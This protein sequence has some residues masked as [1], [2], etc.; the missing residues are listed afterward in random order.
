MSLFTPYNV[1]QPQP[2]EQTAVGQQQ[3][4]QPTWDNKQTRD[5]IKKYNSSPEFFTEY[6][7]NNIRQHAAHHNVPFYEGEFDLVDALAQA[8]AGFFEGFTTLNLMEPADNEYEQIF[9]NLGHLAGFAPGI[10]ATPF[11]FGFKLTGSVGLSKLAKTA[12]ALNDKSVPMAGAKFLTTKAKEIAKPVF[13]I[14]STGHAGAAGD[15]MSFLT[16]NQARHIMEGAFHLGAASAISSWQGG[17]DEMMHSFIHG[18]QAGAVFRSIGNLALTGSETSNKVIRG[19]A[20]SLFMGLPATMRGATTPEQIYEYVMGAYFGKSERPWTEKG[21]RKMLGKMEELAKTNPEMRE[22]MLPELHPDFPEL[23]P[24]VQKLTKEYATNGIPGTDFKGYKTPEE[25][26]L[27]NALFGNEI[28][29]KNLEDI[30]AEVGGYEVEQVIGAAGEPVLRYK[31]GFL[32]RFISRMVSGGA[33][34]ADRAW[35]NAATKLGIPVFNFTFSRHLAQAMLN[36]GLPR[37]LNEAE[38]ERANTEVAKSSESL[39]RP[40]EK[41]SEYVYNLQR[42]NWHIVNAAE[43]VYAVGPILR[44]GALRMKAVDGGTGWGVDMAIR[45]KKDVYVFDNS[46]KKKHVGTTNKWYKYSRTLGRFEEIIEPPKPPKNWGGIGSREISKTGENAIE[47]FL[48]KHFKGVKIA[49]TEKEVEEIKSAKKKGETLIEETIENTKKRIKDVEETIELGEAELTDIAFGEQIAKV[50]EKSIERIKLET[51]ISDLYLELGQLEKELKIYTGTRDIS[52]VDIVDGKVV[53]AK[54]FVEVANTGDTSP[55]ITMSPTPTAVGFAKQHLS[56]M[57][58]THLTPTFRRSEIAGQLV[59]KMAELSDLSRVD[60]INR[61]DELVKWVEGYAKKNGTDIKLNTEAQGQLRQW[62]ARQIFD[63]QVEY[64]GIKDG[65]VRFLAKRGKDDTI[66]VPFTGAGVSKRNYEPLKLLQEVY[67]KAGGKSLR[68]LGIADHITI[69]NKD[70][71]YID[72]ELMRYQDKLE[73]EYRFKGK[74]VELARVLA[75]ADFN[76]LKANLYKKLNDKDY[77]TYGGRGDSDRMYFVKYHPGTND[78]LSGGLLKEVQRIGNMSNEANQ[79]L[80]RFQRAYKNKGGLDSKMLKIIHDKAYM[81]NIL[82]EMALNGFDVSTPQAIKKNAQNM[83]SKGKSSA[84]GSKTIVGIEPGARAVVY[85]EAQGLGINTLRKRNTDKHY[86]NPWS[87]SFFKGTKFNTKTIKEAVDNYTSWLEGTKFKDVEPARRKWILEQVKKGEL[88]DKRLLYFKGG[89]RSHADALKDFVIKNG[90][91]PKISPTEIIPDFISNSKAFNKRSQIWL[92]NGY[93]G[94]SQ[95]IQ[96]YRTEKGNKVK[97]TADGK[98]RYILAED[99]P[100]SIR[101]KM[102][103]DP[104]YSSDITRKSTELGEHIDG[105]IITENRTLRALNADAGMPEHHVQN[106]SFIV[107]PNAQYGA[108]LGKYMMHD[109]G[110]AMSKYMRDA[111]INFIIQ[112]SAAKQIGLRKMGAYKVTKTKGL[113]LLGSEIY[114]LDFSHIKYNY[115]VKTDA[116]MTKWTR[117]VK[118]MMGALLDNSKT[119]FK[120]ETIRDMLNTLMDN[121]F[122]G[123]AKANQEYTDYLKLNESSK[124]Q[125]INDVMK[126]IDNLGIEQMIEGIR[127][128]GNNLFAERLYEYMLSKNKEIL[129]ADYREGQITEAEYQNSMFEINAENVAYQKKLKA[130]KEWKKL[131]PDAA[132]NSVD[133]MLFDKDVRDYRMQVI[134][135][136]IVREATRPIMANS[137]IA[138]MRPYDKAMQMDLDNANPRLKELNNNDKI[139]FLDNGFKQMKIDTGIPGYGKKGI[140]TLGELWEGRKGTYKDVAPEIFETLALRVPMDSV[141]GAHGLTFR[142]FTGRE[143]YGTLLH[144]RTMR[145]LGGADLDGDEAHIYFGG[146]KKGFKKAWREGFEANKEEFYYTKNGKRYVGDNKMSEIPKELIKELELA[147]NI[148]T[149]QDLLTTTKEFK[150]AERNLLNSRGAMYSLHERNRISEA[151]SRGRAQMGASAVVPKQMMQQLHSM[152]GGGAGDIP[153]TS[154]KFT[155]SRR[156]KWNDVLKKYNFTE[157]EV[158]ITPR[159][160]DKWRKLAQEIGRAQVAFSSDPMDELGLKS[161]DFWFKT[162]HNAHFEVQIL[163]KQTKKKAKALTLKDLTAW[164]LKKGLYGTINNLNKAYW[165]KNY[166][167][168]RRWTMDEI[169]SMSEAVYDLPLNQRNS[170]LAKVG[171]LLNPLDW[172]DNAIGRMDATAVLDMYKRVNKDMASK[173]FR[174][175][176]DLLGRTSFSVPESKEMV[177]AIFTIDNSKTFTNNGKKIEVGF[178]LWNPKRRREIARDDAVYAEAVKGLTIPYK[179]LN[180]T[181]SGKKEDIIAARERVLAKIALRAEDYFLNDINDMATFKVI[182]DLARNMS[183]AELQIIPKLHK[184]AE[185]IKDKSYLMASQ[186]KNLHNVDWNTFT[187]EMQSE[188]RKWLKDNKLKHFIPEEWKT[189]KEKISST[190]DRAEIDVAIRKFRKDNKLSKK[191]AEMLDYLLLGT[192]KRGNLTKIRDLEN[193]LGADDPVMRDMISYMKSMAAGTAT[194]KLGWNSEALSTSKSMLNY[195]GAITQFFS[196][197]WKAPTTEQISRAQNAAE[198]IRETVK[199]ETKI[200]YFEESVVPETIE[201]TTGFEGLKE[202]VEIRNVSPELREP[203]TKLLS[204]IKGENNKFQNEFNQVVRSLLGKDINVLNYNDYN[205]LNRWFKDVKTGTIWQQIWGKDGPTDLAKR[206]YWLFPKTINR[207]LMKDDIRLM[208][209]NGL[210]LAQGG[211]ILTGKVMRPTQYVDMVQRWIARTMDGAS[212]TADAYVKLLKENLLFVNSVKEGEVLRQIAVREREFRGWD[213][214]KQLSVED[215][216]HKAEYRDR[217]NDI[218]KH[219]GDKLNQ[220]FNVQIDGKNR[221]M[222]GRQIVDRINKKYTEYFEEMYKFIRGEENWLEK[223]EMIKGYY[224]GD[225]KS[226]I[227]D[228]HRFSKF[229]LDSW[230][231]GENVTTKIG[232]DN[233]RVLA[234]SLMIDM[235]KGTPE[236][237]E[238]LKS[239]PIEPTNK[240]RGSFDYYFPHMHFNKKLAGEGMKRLMK[241]IYETPLS[242]FD[243]NPKKARAKRDKEVKKVIYK[244]HTLTG[245]WQFKE[246]ED[247]ANHDRIMNEIAESRAKKKEKVKWPVDLTKAGNMNSRISHIP[248]WSID[249]SAPEAYARAIVNTYYRQLAQILS[250]NIMQEMYGKMKPIWGE[251]QAIAWQKFMQLYVQDAIGNPTVIPESYVNDPTM[252]L[253]G[254]PYAW[255]ADSNVEKRINKAFDAFGLTKRDMPWL[256]KRTE[257]EEVQEIIEVP[258]P[259]ASPSTAILK[260]IKLLPYKTASDFQSARFANR[261]KLEQSGPKVISPHFYEGK[262]ILGE[263]QVSKNAKLLQDINAPI[264]NLKRIGTKESLKKAKQLQDTADSFS[265][266]QTI[267]KTIT[268]KVKKTIDPAA[269]LTGV[270][271]QQLRHWSNLEG[272]FEMAALLAHPKSAITNVFGGTIHTAQSAGWTN[273]RNARNIDWLR[274]NINSEWKSM[275]DVMQFVVESGV[276]PEY[277][278]YE[279]GLNKEIRQ[280]KNRAFIEDVA[281]KLAN[282]PEM[283]ETSLKEIAKQYGVKDKVVQFAAKFMTVPERM[284]RRDSFM[285]HYIQAWQRYGG[286]ITDPKH[287]F[288]IE[289]AKKGVQATQFLYSAPFRPA[290]AR[291]ALG[292]VMTRFQLWSWNAVRFRNDV[293]RQA[294]IYGLRPGSEEFERYVRT[295]QTDIFTF[296]LANMFAYSIFETALPAP[297]NW[298]QDTAD[299]VFGNEKERDR[300]FF[301]QWPKQLA[302]LQMVTPPILRLLPTSMR[303]MVDDDWSKISKYYIWTMFPFGRVARDLVG[304]GNLIDNP[305]RIMEKTSGFPLLQLQRKGTQ[306]KAELESGE[307]EMPPTPG[308]G[309]SPF[310]FY[311][312]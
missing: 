125:K 30:P 111:G 54:P 62:I 2:E 270:D 266:E 175:L 128:P 81:S 195:A 17:V 291:T 256:Q 162:L 308:S 117:A 61:S 207:E 261:R 252:K 89:Y 185:S 121:R 262:L 124:R 164:D 64:I 98:A 120:T 48:N 73:T 26:A 205:I 66:S 36:K 155:I 40:V 25:R 184:F 190:I 236:Y 65:E 254:T 58:D 311:D 24:E 307:R 50:K 138:R 294:K 289:Q 84:L 38:L 179:L 253:R 135:N 288:L 41:M 238:A 241:K 214:M 91:Q 122:V 276:Y 287:P 282:R 10:M 90:P 145:A 228:N 220:T 103:K 181:K 113:D 11:N 160:Q 174:F 274:Q 230:R 29:P 46:S 86:G 108:L 251:K 21:A 28:K 188:V 257:I 129:E 298:M 280:G 165:G 57:Y 197:P 209:E 183:Q 153:L 132:K 123:E 306:L 6:D 14:A 187:P 260:S 208:E 109:A 115:S 136:F 297:W 199:K 34:G 292:K 272:Q 212:E 206:H 114:D 304:P 198:N 152:L 180:A 68:P 249:A 243:A 49:P 196:E 286:A 219:H 232:V 193:K 112:S 279:A 44:D 312:E 147:P 5:A 101:D 182:T 265:P 186:R 233:L 35:A 295:M 191:Q 275:E 42:R 211:R 56:S 172:S 200:D 218:I 224:K 4:F 106:K 154:D 77:Y 70:G 178:D 130:S 268:K 158:I 204:Y 75:Q 104:L 71:R 227:I 242:E 296:A 31:K 23:P 300:A 221:E 169:R 301:G 149:Y 12:A 139:Y 43:A 299:W 39:N 303:A 235:A 246:V 281:K 277:M 290:F 173:R 171:E 7:L 148:K 258:K 144:S 100:K 229:L 285:A 201:R 210:Y 60:K 55:G 278:I 92:T 99:L 142:G 131:N 151:A 19:V 192:Y 45:N 52:F 102:D 202:G 18:A 143:G 15:A 118:Q 170:F 271:M 264:G 240:W 133:A 226:P 119:P 259:K 237:A 194:S 134:R 310:G 22:K 47:S 107:S 33:E 309:L 231:K 110:N 79:M 245:D 126:N 247:W 217:Y 156:G 176:K 1:G 72:M 37:K 250:R 302:P 293:W 284:I 63:A 105:A 69:K 27:M 9:R 88:T 234:R 213:S 78:A 127:R 67:T 163:N 161:P 74:S 141:S 167:E 267:K 20:G 93:S 137:A 269:E 223:N 76:E 283:S 51:D 3:Q 222:T 140:V 244:N 166:Q 203:V 53:Q 263:Y 146:E 95:F 97:V 239:R 13:K 216:I 225:K 273:L 177:K 305:I 32:D 82:Y 96:N 83:F 87:S 150:S 215:R 159:T 116:H 85:A 189:T 59:F 80:K 8:G 255:W 157:Y 248:G 94:E 16:G 168:G